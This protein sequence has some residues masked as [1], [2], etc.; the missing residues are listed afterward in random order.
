MVVPGR[1]PSRKVHSELTTYARTKLDLVST[2]LNIYQ[3][4]RQCSTSRW[5]LH[6]LNS[7][8]VAHVCKPICLCHK[9]DPK[10][11]LGDQACKYIFCYISKCIM[12]WMSP[13]SPSTFFNELVHYPSLLFLPPLSSPFAVWLCLFL[14]V[15]VPHVETIH[16]LCKQLFCSEYY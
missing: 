11:Y 8:T 9:G 15:P 12:H 1:G 14:C 10:W 5:H 16:Y 3:C 7:A 13:H 2:Y 6:H 4:L